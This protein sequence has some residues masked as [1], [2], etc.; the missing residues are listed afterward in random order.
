LPRAL[1]TLA[2][3]GAASLSGSTVVCES[4]GL[5]LSET[6][7]RVAG[8]L[9]E[10]GGPAPTRLPERESAGFLESRLFRGESRDGEA[11]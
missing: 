1:A 11:D 5:A 10:T 4:F 2:E 7:A 3:D 9:R 6:A 8:M